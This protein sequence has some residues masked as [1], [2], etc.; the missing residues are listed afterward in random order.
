ML[1]AGVD[2]A[3]RGPLA[4]PIFAAAVIL[5]EKNL[6]KGLNDSKKL[7][8]KRR[9]Y[10]VDD[11][12]NLSASWSIG[13]CTAEEIDSI[14]ILQASLLAMQRA[15]ENL[16]ITPQQIL[17][18]G[19]YAPKTDIP[20]KTIVR[21]DQSENSIMAASILAK[22]SR[23]NYMKELDKK[24]PE[25]GFKQHKGYPTKFHLEALKSHGIIKEHRLSFKPVSIINESNK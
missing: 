8:E 19:I 17:V 10:I 25:Y 7:S 16:I 21:G 20:I 5:K 3:G 15:I 6:I 18:D 24:F 1:I 12:K 23:D 13:I 9:E 2:E 14:N 4:G 11:I 22:V